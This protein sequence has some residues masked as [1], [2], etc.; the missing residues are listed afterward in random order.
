MRRADL[1]NA[2]SSRGE[3]AFQPTSHHPMDLLG[4]LKTYLKISTRPPHLASLLSPARF[5]TRARTPELR[6]IRSYGIE[7]C[8]TTRGASPGSVAGR[9]AADRP[10]VS[11]ASRAIL[12][13][14]VKCAFC[15]TRGRRVCTYLG[16]ID[17][18]PCPVHPGV[19]AGRVAASAS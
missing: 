15:A 6:R 19:R 3:T 7:P 11:A 14:C 17:V 9:S 5:L 2:S 16:R 12:P 13:F 1:D 10:A 18:G 8:P 4:H